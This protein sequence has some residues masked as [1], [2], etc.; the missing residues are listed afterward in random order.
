MLTKIWQRYLFT[1]LCKVFFFFLVGF[2]FLYSLIDYSTHMQDFMSSGKV[3][4]KEIFCFYGFQFIKRSVLLLPLALLIASIK[5]L[6]NLNATRE[7]VALQSSGLNLKTLLRPFFLLAGLCCVFNWFSAEKLLPTAL[8]TLE[9]FEDNHHYNSHVKHDP[10][11]VLYLKDNSKLVYQ[12]RDVENNLL[13]DVYWIRSFDD[14][15]RIKTLKADPKDPVADFAD[16]LVRQKDGTLAKVESYDK[17]RLNE[18]KWQ[19][20]MPRKGMIPIENRKVSQLIKVLSHKQQ[21]TKN[22]A[23]EALSYVCYKLIMPL[24]SLLVIMA[25]APFCIR[26]T[27]NVPTFY[28][29]SVSLFGFIAFFTLLDACI[30]LGSHRTIP[31]LLAILLPFGVCSAFFSWK[32]IKTS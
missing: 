7:L 5:V 17:C 15:W 28:I 29:Y 10:F 22:Q 32:F 4:L 9:S 23:S 12:K 6:C 2:F 27:R 11:Q 25:V 13:F 18:L 30:I 16:H 20:N 26:Y 24:L 3:K 14:M 8:N 21:I 1:E 31:P 19:A